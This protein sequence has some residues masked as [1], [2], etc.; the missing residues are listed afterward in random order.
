MS[1]QGIFTISKDFQFSSSHQLEGLAEE[2]PCSRLH[3]HNYTVRLELTGR[4]N[5]TGFVVDYRELAP[6]KTFVDA[7]DHHHL[8]ELLDFNPTAEHLAHFFSEAA[9]AILADYPNV[10]GGK[11]SVSETPKTWATA[12]MHMPHQGD[13]SID[14]D[15]YRWGHS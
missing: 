8:N 10:Y 12:I 11:V 15:R 1:A 13:S 14:A 9:G 6:F 3:G 4:L 5:A 7:L 2:H